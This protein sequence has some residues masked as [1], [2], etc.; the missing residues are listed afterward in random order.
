MTWRI[1]HIYPFLFAIIPVVRLVAENPGWMDVD[2]AAVI[3]TIVLAACGV[4]YGLALLATRRRGSR[5]PPLILLGVVLAFWVY[6]RIAA[7]VQHRTDVSHA[8]LFPLWVAATIGPSGGWFAGRR[9]S[10]E[11]RGF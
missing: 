4:I 1:T 6:V 2:D 9:C 5:L 7:F 11:R 3:L 8:V 10:I